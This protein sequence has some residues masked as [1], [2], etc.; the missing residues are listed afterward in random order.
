MEEALVA[1][2]R[3]QITTLTDTFQASADLA[4][5]RPFTDLLWQHD[6]VNLPQSG[7]G[8]D[9]DVAE[10]AAYIVT[11]QLLLLVLTGHTDADRILE[12]CHTMLDGQFRTL[13]ELHILDQVNQ[14]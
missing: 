7:D 11:L 14:K 6:Q 9:Y 12:D 5:L 2:L 3:D 13:Y 10:G 1:L 4:L 8:L